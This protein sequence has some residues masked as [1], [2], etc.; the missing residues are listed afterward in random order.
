M[1]TAVLV[2]SAPVLLAPVAWAVWSL[3]IAPGRAPRRDA[4]AVRR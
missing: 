2:I 1:S 3:V 4:R